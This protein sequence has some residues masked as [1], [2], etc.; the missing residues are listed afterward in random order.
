M[1]YRHRQVVQY[2]HGARCEGKTSGKKKRNGHDRGKNECKEKLACNG[3]VGNSNVNELVA[4][5]NNARKMERVRS[6]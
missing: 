2:R 1:N 4:E 6:G 5:R 3:K